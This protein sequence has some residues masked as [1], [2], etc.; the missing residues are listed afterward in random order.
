M[1]LTGIIM[2]L[3]RLQDI[4]W[5]VFSSLSCLT[6]ESSF[7]GTTLDWALANIFELDFLSHLSCCEQDLCQIMFARWCWWHI[8]GVPTNQHKTE[9]RPPKNNMKN[10]KKR[11]RTHFKTLVSH[12][13]SNNCIIYLFIY[14]LLTLS[15]P[16]ANLTKPRKFL[17]SWIIQRN[18]K[19]WPLKWKLLMSTS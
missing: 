9:S 14:L 8:G 6:H 4:L 12:G 5:N 11:K 17:K 7:K 13:P 2:N 16:K 18:L 1:S 3:G 15:L 10:E 19:V